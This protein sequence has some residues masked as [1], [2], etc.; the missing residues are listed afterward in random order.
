LAGGP[1][2]RPLLFVNPKSGGGARLRATGSP[3]GRERGIEAVILGP[4]EN[5]AAL[6]QAA[7]TNGAGALGGGWR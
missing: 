6:T 3:S 5:L 7:V 2:R 1:P 4:G